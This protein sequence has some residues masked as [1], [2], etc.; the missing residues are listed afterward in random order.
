MNQYE[1]E[2]E[3]RWLIA[4]QLEPIDARKVYPCFDD[5]AMKATFKIRM[6][7]H[8]SYTALSNMP[9]IDVSDYKDMNEGML[10]ALINVTTPV[11]WTV[12]TFETT[13]KM[14]T[15]ITAFVVCKLGHVTTSERGN[16]IR[17]WASNDDIQKGYTQYALNVTGR[18][19]SFMEDLFNI[20]YPLPKTDLIALPQFT[21]GGMENWGLITFRAEYLL[22]RPQDKSTD[23]KR[24]LC[25]ILA[26]EIGHQARGKILG[27]FIYQYNRATELHCN[28]FGNLV[29]MEWWNDLWLNEGFASY[30]GYLGAH[31]IEPTVSLDHHFSSTVV[32]PMLTMDSGLWPSQSVSDTYENRETAAIEELFN[33]VTYKKVIHKDNFLKIALLNLYLNSFSFSNAIQDDLWD[34]FQK[35]IDE[36]N[37]VQLPAP[38]KAIM[39][40]WTCQSGFP[41]LTVNFSTGNISQEKFYSAKVKNST[42]NTWVIP[43]SW[44]KNG[45]VQPLVWL[46]K[47]SKIFPEMALSDSEYDWIILNV[48]MTGYYRVRYDQKHWRRLTTVLENDPQAI[49]VVNR[50][51]LMEDAYEVEMSG[52]TSYDSVLYLTKYLEKE[53]EIFIWGSALNKLH[54]YDWELILS[55]YELYPVLKNYFLPRILPIYHHC[56]DLLHQRFDM[57]VEEDYINHDLEKILKITCWFRLRDCLN[58]AS[59]IFTKWMKNPVRGG[60]ACFS[61]TICCYGVQLGG[62]KEWDFLWNI[63]KQNSTGWEEK[64]SIFFAL[65]CTH[66]KWLLQRFLQYTLNDSSTPEYQYQ[67]ADIIENVARNEVGHWIAWTFLTDNW[68]HLYN[69]DNDIQSFVNSTL[70]HIQKEKVSMTWKEMISKKEE[71]RNMKCPVDTYEM[72]CLARMFTKRLR[73]NSQMFQHCVPQSFSTLP[74]LDKHKNFNIARHQLT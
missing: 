1:D 51:Q 14:S 44:I 35:V 18:I 26:H 43:V 72:P 22:Y 65:S 11:N 5:P 66:E 21:F 56:A 42:N 41:L 68:S 73:R 34:H 33:F 13:P 46:D 48:N 32:F 45:S 52:Y 67:V 28:W 29:T 24:D 62:E 15:Y 17:I 57:E 2:G 47:S 4:S 25:E 53:D 50:L 59:E 12:T 36:Q 3:S 30:F 49:P 39:D 74:A 71:K 8:P 16:E 64:N 37:D 61:R 58:L 10:S 6:V 69:S 60:P 9:A 7:H 70:E 40:T 27:T 63:Y 54:S 31:Y 23:K 20:S 55:D 19:F 38:V